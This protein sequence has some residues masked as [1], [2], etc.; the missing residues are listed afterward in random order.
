MVIIPHGFYAE[1]I[2]ALKL[3][4]KIFSHSFG[5]EISKVLK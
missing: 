3:I 1:G 4:D 2:I 5:Q